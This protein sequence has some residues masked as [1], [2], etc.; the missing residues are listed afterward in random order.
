MRRF[1]I[2]GLSGL[3]MLSL[4]AAAAWAGKWS[5]ADYPLRVHI[6]QFNAY[7]HYYRPGGGATSTL[8]AVDGEGR[9]DLYENGQPKG[10]DFSYRCSARI[11]VSPGYETYM[12]RWKKP[13]RE[14]AILLPV[15]G[16]KPGDMNE[17]DLNVTLK[18]DTAYFKH[19]G[20]LDEEPVAKFKDWM[21]KHQY[22][23]EHG[24]NQPVNPPAGPAQG[25]TAPQTAQ[26]ASAP[27]GSQ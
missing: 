16:G 25:G 17:C 1:W 7:S 21:V 27:S 19:N 10:F 18:E 20:L 3:G 13:G 9:A 24:L 2:T 8:D 5:A 11:M 6:F 4:V 22:D 12:A 23:P 14:L 15:L 26:P